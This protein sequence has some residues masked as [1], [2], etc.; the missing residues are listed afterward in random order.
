MRLKRFYNLGKWIHRLDM[1]CLNKHVFLSW[2]WLETLFQKHRLHPGLRLHGNS[3]ILLCYWV[4]HVVN[5]DLRGFCFT[6]A[7]K[8]LWHYISV[9]S[10]RLI[11]YGFVSFMKLVGQLRGEFYFTDCLFFGAI[12]SATDPGTVDNVT[13]VSVA[14]LYTTIRMTFLFYDLC[15]W[16]VFS[17]LQ[18][19]CWRSLMNWR[20]TWTS[21]LYSLG[22]V[23]SMMLWPSSSLRKY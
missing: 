20:S 6:N 21:T 17:V 5:C 19:Q 11:M 13:L 4:S 7:L 12:I 8:F 1:V 14:T 18:W 15:P 23:S 9:F 10:H 16:I 22:R 3:H 2:W